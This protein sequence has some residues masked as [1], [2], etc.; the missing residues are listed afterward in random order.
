MQAELDLAQQILSLLEAKNQ[1]LATAES[2]T[3]GLAASAF[4]SVPGSSKVFKGG[5]V[6]YAN[7]AKRAL[8]GVQEASLEEFGAVSQEVAVQMAEGA[9]RALGA[10]WA[11]STSGVA[12]PSGGTPE[13]PVGLVHFAIASP[14]GTEVF[15]EIFGG[16]RNEIRSQAVCYILAKLFQMAAQ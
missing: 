5:I 8:L 7:S 9:R 1:T 2:C 15:H 6:S 16:A 13:K 3:G 10:D 11:L 12:G 14:S 4:V